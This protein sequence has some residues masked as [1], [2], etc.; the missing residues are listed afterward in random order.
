M[1]QPRGPRPHQL[2]MKTQPRIREQFVKFVSSPMKSPPTSVHPW[3]KFAKSTDYRPGDLQLI[4]VPAV[5]YSYY[6]LIT[7]PALHLELKIHE[8]TLLCPCPSVFIRKLQLTATNI[9][10]LHH[11]MT[12]TPA[13]HYPF[14]ISADPASSEVIRGNPK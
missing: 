13:L 2:N 4:S 7:V 8:N 1:F 5:N 9:D 12:S 6:R 3:F 11:S 14:P 10:K